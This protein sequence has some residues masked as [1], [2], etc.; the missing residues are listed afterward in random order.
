MMRLIYI[1]PQSYH[2]LAKYDAAYLRGLMN[3]GLAGEVRFLCSDLLDQPVAAGIEVRRWFRYNRIRWL[4]FKFISYLLS[5]LRI[6]ASGLWGGGSIY[7]FQ[8][9]KFPPIDLLVIVGLRRLAGARVV[10]TAHNVVPHGAEKGS[11]QVLGRIYRA[12]DCIVVHH[13]DTAAEISRRFSVDE[14]KIKTLRHGLIDL[15]G[16]GKPLH[17]SQ[18][19]RFAA[20][21]DT[22]FVFFGRGS[23]Y[24]GLDLLL[25]AWIRTIGSTGASAGLIAIGAIDPALKASATKA[26]DSAHGSLL[27]IDEHATEADLYIAVTSSN[28]VI[29]PH[30]KISQSGVLLSVLGLQIPVVVAPLA[31]LMEPLELA[32]VGWTFDGS[33]EGLARQLLLL[34]ENP[35]MLSDVKNDRQAWRTVKDAY[36]WNAIA[37]EGLRLYDSL[38][39]GSTSR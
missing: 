17:E 24:K 2:G 7:H 6:L 30:R 18:L 9:V 20:S 8:W 37:V 11:H 35:A 19:R 4:P 39:A 5:M 27:V 14:S 34:V 38:G 15:E 29:L 36:D 33:A 13:A 12:V 21:H 1:D 28:A 23:H 3:T 31:G 22:C 25:D 32:P 10:L 26:V 16:N